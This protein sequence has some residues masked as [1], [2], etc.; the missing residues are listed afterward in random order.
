MNMGALA[1]A[2]RKTRER[3]WM[4]GT[5]YQP[6]N[7]AQP[8]AMLC[9]AGLVYDALGFTPYAGVS[10]TQRE[11]LIRGV[12]GKLIGGGTFFPDGD[13]KLCDRAMKIVAEVI[14]ER[15]PWVRESFERASGQKNVDF[16]VREEDFG[17]IVGSQSFVIRF[18]DSSKTTEDDI[19]GV[20]DEAMSRAKAANV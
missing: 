7:K 15:F 20:L 1:T 18:N 5:F 10:E 13:L 12:T 2:F 9:L 19:R 3:K 6:A 8:E 14:D 11:K 16:R 4:K 17:R